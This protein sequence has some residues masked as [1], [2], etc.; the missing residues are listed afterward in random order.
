MLVCSYFWI[1]FLLDLDCH[2]CGRED[3]G[4]YISKGSVEFSASQHGQIANLTGQC[5]DF[6]LGENVFGHLD[7]VL[8]VDIHS[9]VLLDIIENINVL[10]DGIFLGEDNFFHDARLT[11][12]IAIH[13][14]VLHALLILLFHFSLPHFVVLR[15]FVFLSLCALII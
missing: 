5:F 2:H 12:D 9:L 11:V 6:F 15:G 3:G 7:I 8:D 13:T 14:N 10:I 4:S 1:T